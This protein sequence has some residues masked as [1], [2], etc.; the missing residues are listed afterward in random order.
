[1]LEAIGEVN[2]ELLGGARPFDFAGVDPAEVARRIQHETPRLPGAAADA[3]AARA[4]GISARRLR[5]QLSG[6]LD[7]I[8]ARAL[9][10]S[11]DAR[12]ASV[13]RLADD[14]RRHLRRQPI[15]I[16]AG[17]R[18]YRVFRYIERNAIQVSGHHQVGE[19]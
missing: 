6:D 10:K 12:Y 14:V 3:A 11:P 2:S 1:M 17:E 18:G 15:S 8:V 16:R 7:A 19:D 9:A 4:R 13:A 5:A